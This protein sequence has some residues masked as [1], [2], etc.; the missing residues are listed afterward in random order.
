MYNFKFGVSETLTAFQ[1]KATAGFD[2]MRRAANTFSGVTKTLPRSIQQIEEEMRRLRTAQS[3]ALSVADVRRYG[4]EIQKLDRQLAHLR[5]ESTK[6]GSAL[7][8]MVPAI[9]AMGVG[10][11]AQDA[12]RTSREM[13]SFTRS[14]NFASGGAAIGEKSM[15]GIRKTVED[16]GLPLRESYEGF[17]TLQAG[18]MDS[19]IS[20]SQTR[21]LFN[22][23]GE[24]A[25]VFG[26]GAEETKGSLL[27]LAQMASKGTVS[28]EELRGQLGERLP[29][30]F[31][32]AARSLGVTTEKLGD[33]LKGGEVLS[34][35]FLP[36]FAAELHKTFGAQAMASV[37]SAT[38]NW[39]RMNTALFEAKVLFGEGLM[40]VVL[41][42]MKD[43]LI[44]GLKFIKEHKEQIGL[45]LSIV[46]GGA[47]AYYSLV[48][49]MA[50]YNVWMALIQI[51]TIGFTAAMGLLNLTML[52][53]PFVW[54]ALGIG[55]LVGGVIYAWNN[56]EGFRGTV[57]GVWNV[58]KSGFSVMT[59]VVKWI[60]DKISPAFW[61]FKL[62]FEAVGW[63][64]N[65]LMANWSRISEFL[66]PVFDVIKKYLLG[67]LG[68]V[69]DLFVKLGKVP[70]IKAKFDEGYYAEVGNQRP[71]PANQ[72]LFSSLL[73][74]PGAS[75]SERLGVTS[76]FGGASKTEGALAGLKDDKL[77][78]E[79]L[80]GGGK[81]KT[82]G[83][84]ASVSGSGR[85]AI[86]NLNVA[87]MGDG[88][89]INTMNLKESESQIREYI[90]RIL[91]SA[92][93]DVQLSL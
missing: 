1:S 64:W 18:V 54:L 8:G 57:M 16:L 41:T 63:A 23:I 9:G 39:N 74:K 28:A 79:T 29:G 33:M 83:E 45:L 14:I 15:S 21:D 11:V 49:G 40:P 53:N 37:N 10:F 24:A 70:A 52:A 77:S 46:A 92:L 88:I 73:G 80:G 55:A 76:M 4:A 78:G 27:A 31:S 66:K 19:G 5:G 86:V 50:V 38:A 72:D 59:D 87:K 82:K 25:S 65:K 17:K 51:P 48:A 36:K 58:M 20:V 2:T 71:A 91:L 69:Y 43:Y 34:K 47:V 89:T 42:F 35:D 81:G 85:P 67:P 26:M 7:G 75:L 62:I 90:N 93:N 3:T 22:G 12:M 32:I 84:A 61:H 68:L 30:A 60:W 6:T 44:P 13:D 56:F